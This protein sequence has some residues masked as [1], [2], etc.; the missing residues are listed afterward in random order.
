MD[1][2]LL[3]RVGNIGNIAVVAGV[4]KQDPVLRARHGHQCP[5]VRQGVVFRILLSLSADHRKTDS[6]LLRLHAV[7][8]HQLRKSL[9]NPGRDHL[10]LQQILI[11]IC[12]IPVDPSFQDLLQHKLFRLVPV[13]F[14]KL[15]EACPVAVHIGVQKGRQLIVQIVLIGKIHQHH[16]GQ[17]LG[18]VSVHAHQ[19]MLVE[20]GNAKLLFHAALIPFEIPLSGLSALDQLAA[21]L[22][23]NPHIGS[24]L[25]AGHQRPVQKGRIFPLLC[26]Q[27]Q[28][29]HDHIPGKHLIS[30]AEPEHLPFKGAQLDEKRGA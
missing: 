28:K 13:V 29:L 26:H 16:L 30:R 15:G 23:Q 2:E 24:G 19:I 27:I 17:R 21:D 20:S 5:S 18:G 25:I 22:L 9:R 14:I 1:E 3:H 12:Q 4:L 11:Q 7:H 6:R 10:R 8:K